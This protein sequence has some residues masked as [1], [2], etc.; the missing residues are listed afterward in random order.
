MLLA[1]VGDVQRL[2]VGSIHGACSAWQAANNGS[3]GGCGVGG[4]G[5]GG[6]VRREAGDSGQ[7]GGESSGAGAGPSAAAAG[8]G[9]GAPGRLLPGCQHGAPSGFAVA[10]GSEGLERSKSVRFV[11][12]S[13]SRV[14]LVVPSAWAL[15]L[16]Q[17]CGQQVGQE[18]GQLLGLEREEPLRQGGGM[19]LP[20]RWWR[21]GSLDVLQ[22]NGF[23]A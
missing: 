14:V 1:G 5:S 21:G 13:G 19:K 2:V 22:G 16:L 8:S 6:S 7:L 9:S 12:V 4:S 10:A 23:T 15:P 20:L 11:A 3:S 18:V 17:C